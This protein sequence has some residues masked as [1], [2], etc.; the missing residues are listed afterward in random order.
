MQKNYPQVAI[1]IYLNATD[2]SYY[3]NITQDRFKNTPYYI[4]GEQ[5]STI[6]PY[7][8]VWFIPLKCTFGRSLDDKEPYDETF[9]IDQK[10]TNIKLYDGITKFEWIHC[11]QHFEGYYLMD[12]SVENWE[13]L[14]KL[15]A[16]QKYDVNH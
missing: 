12:Y 3:L 4:F 14:G 11:D 13:I 15:L 10:N 9:I 1:R 5:D 6:S 16:A 7:N 8:Y 2:N